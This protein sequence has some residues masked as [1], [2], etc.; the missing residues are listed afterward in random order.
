ME[1]GFCQVPPGRCGE[2]YQ[3]ELRVCRWGDIGM[4]E[5]V[6]RHGLQRDVFP[7]NF[8]TNVHLETKIDGYS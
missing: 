3:E 4:P 6:Y 1:L 5:Q 2:E 8:L 7:Q